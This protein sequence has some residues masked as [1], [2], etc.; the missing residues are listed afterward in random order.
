MI[1][2]KIIKQNKDVRAAF[3]N[4]DLDDDGLINKEEVM[5]VFE[6]LTIELNDE[7]LKMVQGMGEETMAYEGFNIFSFFVFGVQPLSQ[8]RF[9]QTTTQLYSSTKNVIKY[10]QLL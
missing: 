10:N 6:I 8:A 7:F 4:V 1:T 3:K 5:E 2:M 9:V